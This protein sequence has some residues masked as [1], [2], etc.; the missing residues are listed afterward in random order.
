MEEKLHLPKYLA[1]YNYLIS[2]ANKVSISGIPS[3]WLCILYKKEFVKEVILLRSSETW[4]C[5]KCNIENKEYI[6]CNIY[7]REVNADYRM[8]TLDEILRN[9]KEKYSTPIIL[10]GDFNAHIGDLNQMDEKIITNAMFT[11]ERKT[12][13]TKINKRGRMLSELME[14][15]GMIVLNGRSI[16]DEGGASTYLGQK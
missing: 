11:G 10:G 6:I 13:D 8:E 14:E 15:L 16:S 12:Q 5:M 9:L 7:I 3:G 2:K 1:D 4:L